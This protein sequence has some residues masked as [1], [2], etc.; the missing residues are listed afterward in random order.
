[1]VDI[2]IGK[3]RIRNLEI[4]TLCI[5]G[6]I[7]TLVIIIKPD[8]LIY[9]WV[10]ALSGS[11]RNIA[12]GTSNSILA[13]FLISLG[14]NSSVL[15][16]VPYALVIYLLSVQNPTSWVWITLASGVGAALGEIV[17][18]YV[19]RLISKSDKMRTSEVGEKFHRMKVQFEKNPKTV[20]WTVFLF[21][22]T[23]LP[24]DIILVPLGMME[25]DYK[26]TIFPCMVGKTILCGI[27]C[28]MGYFVGTYINF[29][30]DLVELYPIA[31]VLYFVIPSEGVNPRADLISFSFV[32]IFVYLV[33]RIN[34]EG[35]IK[36][37]SKVRKHFQA[38]LLEGDNK[39]LP[40]L[41]EMYE[42]VNYEAF[43]KHMIAL[44]DKSPNITFHDSTYHFDAIANKKSKI[45]HQN[46]NYHIDAIYDKSMAYS[47][48]MEFIDFFFSTESRAVTDDKT[49]KNN[50]SSQKGG[51]AEG[52]QKV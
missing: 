11:I 8:T 34:L 21:A 50:D 44:A 10:A 22:L 52:E 32:F 39:T 16:V 33:A 46:S 35:F 5:L 9:D 31:G 40:E 14:G 25:Y 26:R 36:R 42:V 27:I 51:P 41:A 24:D 23:P 28:L 29:M 4:F 15:I 17:S 49:P 38:M 43:E 2:R 19:G 6:L 30:D 45:D 7:Y 12:T 13:S 20:P 3:L 47:Q 18:Y 37:R 48:S 1:M